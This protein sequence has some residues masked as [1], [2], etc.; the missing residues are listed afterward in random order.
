MLYRETKEYNSRRTETEALYAMAAPECVAGYAS[1]W[2]IHVAGVRL[3]GW[4]V[5]TI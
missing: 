4:G 1:T 5:A 3:D 2:W